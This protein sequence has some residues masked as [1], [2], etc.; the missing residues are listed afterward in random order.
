MVYKW[1]HPSR[2][3]CD[4]VGDIYKN[5]VICRLIESIAAKDIY[6][7][8][9]DSK[10]RTLFINMVRDFLTEKNFSKM[11]KNHGVHLISSSTGK[12]VLLLNIT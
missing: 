5:D 8:I 10:S 12:R 9:D 4:S 11:A 1:I 6:N 3:R 2:M 7:W